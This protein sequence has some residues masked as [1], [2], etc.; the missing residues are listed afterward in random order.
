MSTRT[1]RSRAFRAIGALAVAALLAVPTAALAAPELGDSAYI[2]ARQGYAG[3]GAFPIYLDT[4]ADPSAPGEPDLWAFC[5]EHDVTARTG[6]E[7]TIGGADDYLGDN[8][9]TDPVVQGKVLWILAHSYPA[10]SLADLGTAAGAPGLDASDAFEA[11]QYAIWR[12]TDLGF[13]AAWPWETP[14]SEAVYH[15]LADGAEA[16]GGLTPA[17]LSITLSITG[18]SGPHEAG[19]LVGPFTV[20]TDRPSLR[21]TADPAV[22]ITDAAGTPIDADAVVD[23]QELYLDLR[24]ADTSGTA[25]VTATADGSTVGGRIVS[26]PTTPG[27]TPSEASHAQT[28]ALVAPAGA[29][30]TASATAEWVGT[31][32]PPVIGTTLVDAADGDQT[33]P[34]NGGTATD[35]I[36]YQHLTPGVEYTVSGELMRKSD[37]S[38]TGITGSATFTPISPDGTVDVSFTVPAGYAGQQLVAFETLTQAGVA[39]PVAV[40]HDLADAAQTVTV[41]AAPVVPGE[42]APAQHGGAKELAETGSPIAGP[43]LAALLLMAL[44]LALTPAAAR[45]RPVRR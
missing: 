26:V 23:G 21:V 45:R 29:V 19:T 13:D 3:T 24:D 31:A 25:T 15:Y 37:G 10:V 8:F 12:Y 14:N 40:H 38:A 18:P 11:T 34:W 41:E 36:A 1:G 17:E 35:T 43:A 39:E 4:P 6:L 2:G 9:F 44:G 22:A 32:V 7:G 42:P 30:S 33:L 28:I 16:S 27:G 20:T 5:I